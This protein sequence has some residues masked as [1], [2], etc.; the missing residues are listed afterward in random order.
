MMMLFSTFS[1]VRTCQVF[2]RE[3]GLGEE[4]RILVPG[5]GDSVAFIRGW[6]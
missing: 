4:D 6:Q 1:R 5:G 3:S 2:R